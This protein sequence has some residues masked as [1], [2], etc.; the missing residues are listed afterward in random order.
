MDPF[1][2][3]SLCLSCYR[4]RL[5]ATYMTKQTRDTADL[6]RRAIEED[7]VAKIALQRGLV[8][9]RAF[10][11]HIQSSSPSGTTLESI[12]AAVHRY[13][14]EKWASR[15]PVGAYIAKLT[16]RDKLTAFGIMNS[17]QTWKAVSK[18]PEKIAISRGDI[19]RI[20]TGVEA[21]TLIL[22]SKNAKTLLS[23]IPRESIGTTY[24]KL[25]EVIV[26]LE[27]SAWEAVGVNAA[28]ANQFALNNVNIYYQFGYG[29]PPSV[30]FEVH[31]DSA[32]KAYESLAR[33]RR[34][35]N[36]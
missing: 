10:S 6:V 8:N 32:M 25:A 2:S 1:R 27:E 24:E 23:A 13:P 11:R 16:L 28:L 31:E 34:E 29:P 14:L 30:V 7:P 35:A 19:L 22:D 3:K 4:M 12:V 33:L 18:L 9:I 20:I 21:T 17:E 36:R 5:V 26:T 15:P